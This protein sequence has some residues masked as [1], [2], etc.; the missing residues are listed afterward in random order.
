MSAADRQRRELQD[1]LERI[2]GRMQHIQREI[3][4]SGQPPSMGELA[5]LKELGVEYGRI[6]EQLANDT[7]GAGLA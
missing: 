2:V 6:V 7:G 5:E 3:R 4:A 1:R